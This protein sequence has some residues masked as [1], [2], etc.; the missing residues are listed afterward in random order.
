[1]MISEIIPIDMNFSDELA[2]RAG[3]MVLCV[4]Q[5]VLMWGRSVYYGD[6][7]GIDWVWQIITNDGL[8]TRWYLACGIGS[9][10]EKFVDWL[11]EN[12]A[13]HLEW[14]LFHPEWL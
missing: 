14:L 12:D 5:Y 8:P 9:D 3:E 13:E 10:K 7:Y 4:N 1:M 11:S 6:V 2:K